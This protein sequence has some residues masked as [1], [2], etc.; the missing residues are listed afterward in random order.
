M[1]SQ[2]GY[3][4]IELLTKDNFDTW[5]LQVRAVLVKND[6]WGY[7]NGTKTKPLANEADAATMAAAA[8]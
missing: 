4:R 3:A 8:A 1:N 7:V 5:K 2:H 6:A